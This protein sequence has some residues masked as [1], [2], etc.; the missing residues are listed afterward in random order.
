VICQFKK[1]FL[2]DL[3]KLPATYRK[4]IEKLVFEEFPMMNGLPGRLDIRK[5]QGYANYYRIRIG[6]YRIGCE[7]ETGNRITAGLSLKVSSAVHSHAFL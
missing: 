5:I 2:R 6:D 1:A 3:A 7:I 4:R